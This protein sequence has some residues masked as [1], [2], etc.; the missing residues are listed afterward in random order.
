MKIWLDTSKC[1]ELI[2]CRA[3]NCTVAV[4]ACRQFVRVL[5]G[6][7]NYDEC[8]GWRATAEVGVL[9]VIGKYTAGWGYCWLL[10][11]IPQGRGTVG[12]W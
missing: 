12:Y 7:N 9:L 2:M 5:N 1:M 11:S 8:A 4:L 3:A 10:A 6:E